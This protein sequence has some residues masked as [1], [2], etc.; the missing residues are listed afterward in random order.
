MP[1][2]LQME[3]IIFAYYKYTYN[4][5]IENGT[6]GE[7]TETLGENTEHGEGGLSFP[8]PFMQLYPS[9]SFPLSPRAYNWLR[10]P[11]TCQIVN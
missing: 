2:M 10:H 8:L 6:L 1:Q 4:G 3:D 5:K 11:S 9:P 7:N